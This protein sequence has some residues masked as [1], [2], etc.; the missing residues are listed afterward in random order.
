MHN[1]SE[2]SSSGKPIA[3]I[4]AIHTEPNASKAPADGLEAVV[5]LANGARVMLT[6]NLW[7]DVG[8]VNGA[9]GTI[10]VICYRSGGPPDV[11]TGVVVH[12]DKYCGPTLQDG[13]NPITPIRRTWSASGANCSH[14]QLP[15]KLSWTVTIHKSQSLTLDKVVV[16]VGKEFS[17][18]LTF[19]ACSRVPSAAR[20]VRPAVPLPAL[21]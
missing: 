5:C 2:L 14:L 11:P 4:K 9:M 20:S 8:L 17:A 3:A 7:V 15:L 16:D 18:G 21:S 19:V 1:V 12:F 6:S 13:T 10:A